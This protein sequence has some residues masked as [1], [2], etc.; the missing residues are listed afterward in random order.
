[1]LRITPGMLTDATSSDAQMTPG[2]TDP[3]LFWAILAHLPQR[4]RSAV[5]HAT[6]RGK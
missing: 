2:I 6:L 4:A 1:M 5:T 3:K